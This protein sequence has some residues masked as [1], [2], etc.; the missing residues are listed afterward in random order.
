[1]PTPIPDDQKAA[2][3]ALVL[4]APFPGGTGEVSRLQEILVNFEDI[5]TAIGRQLDLF[6]SNNAYLTECIGVFSPNDSD[7]V[8]AG[9]YVAKSDRSITN[10]VLLINCNNVTTLNINTKIAGIGLLNSEVV[11]MNI[12]N[13]VLPYLY[14]GPQSVI[15]LLSGTLPASLTYL[16]MRFIKNPSMIKSVKDGTVISNTSIQAGCIFN[17][18][19]SINPDLECSKPVTDLITSD[20][21]HNSIVL[22]WTNPDSG[23]LFINIFYRITGSPSWLPIDNDTG[24]YNGI[25][26]YLFNNLLPDT[27]YEFKVAV[28]CNNGGVAETETSDKTICC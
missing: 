25:I 13:F 22:T 20:V 18:Q 15:E 4:V 19:Q 14:M 6:A 9:I 16:T 23:Y 27:N 3:I 21:T 8:A 1:M 2:F 24:W 5:P 12:T 11:N 26:S 17:P 28:T 7:L 10:A